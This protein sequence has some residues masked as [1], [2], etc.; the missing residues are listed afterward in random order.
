M[1]HQIKFRSRNMAQDEMRMNRIV[2][3]ALVT[4]LVYIQGRSTSL[5]PQSLPVED[6]KAKANRLPSS[7]SP[8][9]IPKQHHDILFCDHVLMACNSCAY[10]KKAVFLPA[11]DDDRPVFVKRSILRILVHIV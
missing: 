10:K 11:S 8:I 9:A 2:S 6:N 5:P 1:A 4:A 3:I 7:K